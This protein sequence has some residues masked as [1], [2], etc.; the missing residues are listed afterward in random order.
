[1]NFSI[2]NILDLFGKNIYTKSLAAGLGVCASVGSIYSVYKT[3]T[4][5]QI[6]PTTN[7]STGLALPVL[8]S[9]IYTELSNK[10]L[11]SEHVGKNLDVAVTYHGVT[12]LFLPPM[13]QAYLPNGY[14]A[15]SHSAPNESTPQPPFGGG[16]SSFGM[17]PSYTI[18]VSTDMKNELLKTPVPSNITIHGK[19]IEI[20][21]MKKHGITGHSVIYFKSD[22]LSE[23]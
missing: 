11:A 19:V 3:E 8:Q 9:K 10:A 5:E 6:T 17:V 15:I 14:V 2:S 1:M 4:T 23:N 7:S 16:S 22:R 18:A 12:S 20:D 21:P 13:E